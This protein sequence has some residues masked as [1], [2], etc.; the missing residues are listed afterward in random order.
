MSML[1]SLVGKFN[2]LESLDGVRPVMCSVQTHDVGYV[3]F[4][5]ALTASQLRAGESYELKITTKTTHQQGTVYYAFRTSKDRDFHNWLLTCP[6]LGH[7]KAMRLRAAY[8]MLVILSYLRDKKHDALE[9]VKGLGSETV[10]RLVNELGP[11]VTIYIQTRGVD[12][13]NDDS[14]LGLLN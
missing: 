14:Q 2:R 13:G 8:P 3:V 9:R 12:V 5:D 6:R 4:T 1:T 7:S 11:K 10:A